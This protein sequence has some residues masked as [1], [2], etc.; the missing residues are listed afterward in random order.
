MLERDGEIDGLPIVNNIQIPMNLST[1]DN[2][3][4]NTSTKSFVSAT[5]FF[6]RLETLRMYYFF[7]N[8]ISFLLVIILLICT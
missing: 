4:E 2:V 8:L 3:S 5:V 6:F 7:L 1:F